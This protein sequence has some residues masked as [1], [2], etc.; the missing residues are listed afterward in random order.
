MRNFELG[1]RQAETAAETILARWPTRPR[2]GIVLG[3]GLGSVVE[4]SQIEAEFEF[5]EI[6]GFAAATAPGHRGRCVC[7]AL[8]DVPFVAMDGRFH[9]Y[10]GHPA[11][12]TAFPVRVMTALGIDVLIL[13]NA[14]GGMNPNYRAGDLMLVSDHVN[15]T[16]DNPL[17]GPTT[18]HPDGFPDLACPYDRQLIAEADAIARRENFSAHQGVY[19]GVVGPNY[20]TRAEYRF[21]RRL[22]GDAVGMSTVAEVIVAV[23]CRLRVLAVSVV[24]NVCLPDAPRTADCDSVIAVAHDAAPKLRAI[25]LGIIASLPAR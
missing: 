4:Q 15:L 13:T 8:Q 6:P 16:F 1:T 9:G 3:S 10:E 17:V 23:Q 18:N 20:E 25:L 7:G 19:V 2:V 12:L 11:A 24:T 5:A 14:C 21:F 22:G